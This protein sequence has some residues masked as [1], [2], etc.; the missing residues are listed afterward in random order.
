MRGAGGEGA[1]A[2]A[3]PD[4]LLARE[5][6]VH[7]RQP[8]TQ[9]AHGALRDA[10]TVRAVASSRA[11]RRDRFADRG[12]GRGEAGRGEHLREARAVDGDLHHVIPIRLDGLMSDN[13]EWWK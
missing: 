10:K 1:P 6:G 2:Q 3:R 11:R 7:K 8:R 4:E 12:W 9:L 5:L 13:A